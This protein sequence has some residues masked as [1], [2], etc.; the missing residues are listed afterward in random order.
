MVASLHGDARD[1][2]LAQGPSKCPGGC[3]AALGGPCFACHRPGGGDPFTVAFDLGNAQS[4]PCVDVVPTLKTTNMNIALLFPDNT[5]ALLSP[6]DAER[7]QGLPEGWTAACYPLVGPGGDRRPAPRDGDAERREAERWG[8]AGNAVAVPVARWLGTRLADPCRFKYVPSARDRPL[9]IGAEGVMGGG[10]GGGGAGGG[11]GGGHH[12]PSSSHD[13]PDPSAEAVAAARA[14]APPSDEYGAEGEWFACAD[15]T[16]EAA[17]HGEATLASLAALGGAGA[18]VRA[19]LAAALAAAGGGGGGGGR[20]PARPVATPSRGGRRP[21]ARPATGPSLPQAVGGVPV[22][23]SRA[24]GLPVACGGGGGDGAPPPPPPTPPPTLTDADNAPHPPGLGGGLT[25]AHPG[26]VPDD[27]EALAGAAGDA[28]AA[29]GGRAAGLTVAPPPPPTPT[30]G[31]PASPPP[32]PLPRASAAAASDLAE[33]TA[34]ADA[35]LAG[36]LPHEFQAVMASEEGRAAARAARR[37]GRPLDRGRERG[38]GAAWPRSAWYVAGLGRHAAEVGD[39]PVRRPLVPLFR[40]LKGAGCGDGGPGARRAPSGRRPVPPAA[41]TTYLTRMREQGWDVTRTQARARACGA[42]AGVPSD[43]YSLVFLPGVAAPDAV[44]DVVWARRPG[45]GGGWWPAEALDPWRLPF[46]RSLPPGVAAAMPPSTAE[47]GALLPGEEGGGG[48][49]GGAGGDPLRL[50]GSGGGAPATPTGPPPAA[51]E[52]PLGG[53]GV[54][55]PVVY[56]PQKGTRTRSVLVVFF[57]GGGAALAPLW[58]SPASL[59]P[60]SDVAGSAAK[61]AAGRAKAAAAAGAGR[62]AAAAVAAA[63][64]APAPGRAAATGAAPPPLAAFTAALKAATDI[65]AAKDELAVAA[66]AAAAGSLASDAGAIAGVAGALAGAEPTDGGGSGS[67][68]GARGAA[69]TAAAAAALH[70]QDRLARLA[71]ALQSRRAADAAARANELTRC[72]RCAACV[73]NGGGGREWQRPRPTLPRLLLG[74]AG[75]AVPGHARRRRRGGRPRGRPGRGPG[76]VRGRRR[77]GGLVA[78]GRRMVRRDSCRVRPVPPQARPGVRGRG[79]GARRPLVA[80]RPGAADVGPGG[81]GGAGGGG[82]GGAGARGGQ[83]GRRGGG[84]GGGAGGARARGRGRGGRA[85]APAGGRAARGRAAT[86]RG[87]G[88]GDRPAGRRPAPQL[89]PPAGRHGRRAGL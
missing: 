70:S 32:P 21:A 29:L 48:G 45:P 80:H 36:L 58:A 84:G 16:G 6:G 52:P 30:D 2:L 44:G 14:A 51:A 53:S 33:A 41:M 35:R 57:P 19:A 23:P 31:L 77:P 73:P 79:R 8:Q 25:G 56:G 34:V 54:P 74:R 81:V 7:L 76:R 3:G 71:A 5:S 50:E 82:A 42:L 13:A 15:L 55:P 10:V 59:V 86:A 20:G 1:V 66:L 63:A 89:R 69:A 28:A 26:P 62:S 11:G 87:G 18:A 9:T 40:F 27:P 49:E 24:P 72:G 4:P 43:A 78:A 39:A 38:G 37:T 12:P 88:G 83:A 47:G 46:S 22:L 75:P 64:P 67:G 68:G 17:R 65:Q 60:F 61:A 85:R